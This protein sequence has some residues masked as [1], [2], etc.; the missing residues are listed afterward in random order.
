MDGI[1]TTH[2]D[3]L[4]R[5]ASTIAATAALLVALLVAAVPSHAATFELRTSASP[6][7]SAPAALDGRSVQG[8]IHVFAA[9]DAGA[10][11]VR[12]WLDDPTM[13]GSPRKTERTAPWDFIGSSPDDRALPF[14]TTTIADGQ[15][16]I[17]AAISLS[18]GGTEV[19]HAAFTVANQAPRLAAAPASLS[20]TVDEGGTTSAQSVAVTMS[21][22]SAAFY[23]AAADAPWIGVTP[24]NGSTPGQLSVTVDASGLAAGTH[25]G[26]VT[27]T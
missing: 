10:T 6:D 19:I 9:P 21:D 27:V 5:I 18:G 7:R 24:A 25:T 16:T 15:H 12:F 26:A 3:P 23:G 2:R 14:N 17:T 11:Q 4:R 13:A 22:A 1:D 8:N 20:F